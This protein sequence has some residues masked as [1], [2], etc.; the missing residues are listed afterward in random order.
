MQDQMG[1]VSWEV[2]ILRKN[3]KEMLVIKN[4]VIKL[5]NTFDGLISRLDSA[6]E[7]L[8]ELE[9]I[10]IET[11]KAA[12]QREQ[13]LKKKIHRKW[14]NYKRFNICSGNQKKKKVKGRG[15][16]FETITPENFSKFMSDTNHRS[17]NLREHQAG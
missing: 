10:L 2:R 4:T 3:T 14:H 12:K 9:D 8:S 6:E 16:I 17:R 7:R 13:R 11:S 5:E 1:N 15:E